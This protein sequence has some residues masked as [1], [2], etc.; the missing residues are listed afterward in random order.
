MPR[1]T[2]SALYWILS[3]QNEPVKTVIAL[4]LLQGA[5]RNKE[6]A[7]MRPRGGLFKQAE[8]E[9]RPATPVGLRHFH[10]NSATKQQADKGLG[11][12]KVLWTGWGYPC[13]S[14]ESACPFLILWLAPRFVVACGL[15]LGHSFTGNSN[16][17]PGLSRIFWH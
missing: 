14:E 6:M 7:G 15:G 1:T 5:I 10:E 9:S 12:T 11:G 3:L 13:R 17:G 16:F 4:F 8:A 2:L